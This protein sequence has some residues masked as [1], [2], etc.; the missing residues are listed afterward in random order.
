VLAGLC[1][2]MQ[3]AIDGVKKKT[4]SSGKGCSYATA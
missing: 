4:L 1:K 3:L 2:T